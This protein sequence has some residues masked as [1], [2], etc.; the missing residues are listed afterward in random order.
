EISDMGRQ[1]L[2]SG[3]DDE[4]ILNCIKEMEQNGIVHKRYK[5]IEE[6][7]SRK[8]T[9]K[10]IRHH[11][12]NVLDSKLCHLALKEEEK[13]FIKDWI[14]CNKTPAG[15]IEW[16]QLRLE[17]EETF[18]SLKSENKIKNYYYSNL[19][20]LSR[21]VG[22]GISDTPSEDEFEVDEV[23]MTC[24]T[25]EC[26]IDNNVAVTCA[27]APPKDEFYYDIMP[28]LNS[29]SLKSMERSYNHNNNVMP[30]TPTPIYHSF[31]LPRPHYTASEYQSKSGARRS[32]VH[33]K[34]FY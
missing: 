31:T 27:A 22:Q 7:L 34:I 5:I 13:Q 15:K 14:R 16:K 11:Y 3:E 4:V 26:E 18:K 6:R 24:P 10:Q 20:R 2:F 23:T 21:K 32:V 29:Y 28:S 19:K 25:P 33:P 9:A 30:A 17:M 1:L 12:T 8:F